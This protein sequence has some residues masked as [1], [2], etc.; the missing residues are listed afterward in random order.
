MLCLGTFLHL[1]INCSNLDRKEMVGLIMTNIDPNFD[2]R[3]DSM[4][5]HLVGC[6]KNPSKK[7]LEKF[8]WMEKAQ[9]ADITAIFVDVVPKINPNKMHDLKNGLVALV[10]DD[11]EIKG[12]TVV[13]LVNEVDKD[14]MPSNNNPLE[15][16]LAGM[17]IYILKF[18]KNTMNRSSKKTKDSTVKKADNQPISVEMSS[19][20]ADENITV[21]SEDIYRAAQDFCLKYEKELGLLPLCQIAFNIDPL[22]NN[23]RSMYTD[24]IRC[25]Q[26]VREAILQ[27]KEIPLLVFQKDWVG[28]AIDHYESLIDRYELSTREF[29]YDGA[30]YLHRAFE[31]YSDHPVGNPNP[32]IFERPY[33]N[34][35]NRYIGRD[36]P[37]SISFYIDDF[38][39]YKKNDPS[40]YVQ[41]PMDYL[42]E[43]CNLGSCEE[44][45][46]TFWVCRFII[47]SS[48]QI[49]EDGLNI[50]ELWDSVYINE[51]L[52][53]TQ[54]DMYYYALLQLYLLTLSDDECQAFLPCDSDM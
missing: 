18:T 3:N 14:H 30:K 29:L 40:H 20:K 2:D 25:P 11:A 39:W 51:E 35:T 16:I 32:Y 17:L 5:S 10:Q 12:D 21:E 42:W 27:I 48:F 54:E 4:I 52:L 19:A 22:H 8:K 15:S 1:I 49:R 34:K 23:V 31:N 44:P 41:P 9:Y 38:L 53:K 26:K 28:R 45:K 13:D 6:D 37:S 24:Y 46:M 50:E 43:Q 7:V 47:S 33:K 36:C